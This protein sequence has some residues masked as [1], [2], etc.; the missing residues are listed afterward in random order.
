[1]GAELVTDLSDQLPVEGSRVELV[2]GTGHFLQLEDPATVNR[3][4]L[5]F[6]G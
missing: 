5:D 3:L 1:M 2:P 4:I 6:I